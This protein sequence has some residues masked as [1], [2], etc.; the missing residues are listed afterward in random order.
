LDS[1]GSGVRLGTWN[2]G[3]IR[4]DCVLKLVEIPSPNAEE[5]SLDTHERSK[6]VHLG[7][8]LES[9]ELELGVVRD[10]KWDKNALYT[11]G[12]LWE[13]LLKFIILKERYDDGY[14]IPCGE[15]EKDGIAL[16]PD[17]MDIK[18]WVHE[19]WKATY[20]SMR[21]DPEE[22]YRTG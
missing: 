7:Q 3:V 17:G 11:A 12:F 1:D 16:T 4:R 18:D 6:G 21:H 14:L 9:M 19:E 20:K 13:R 15:L 5:F 10:G 8:I 22:Y 2:G